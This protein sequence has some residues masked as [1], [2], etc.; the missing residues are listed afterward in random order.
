MEEAKME[1]LHD[2]EKRLKTVEG[3]QKEMNMQLKDLQSSQYRIETKV[4]DEGQETRKLLTKFIDHHFDI[5]GKKLSGEKEIW[6]K[7]I[8]V[9]GGSSGLVALIIHLT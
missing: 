8:G 3:N 7:V 2:H 4:M 9:V 5:K 6:L 1:M